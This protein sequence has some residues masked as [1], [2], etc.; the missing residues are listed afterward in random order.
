V[1]GL[2][3]ATVSHCTDAH[4]DKNSFGSDDIHYIVDFDMA[5]LGADVHGL[6]VLLPNCIGG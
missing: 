5:I 1:S 3:E 6:F 2:I 4:M